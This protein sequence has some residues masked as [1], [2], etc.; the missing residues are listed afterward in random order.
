[1]TN[2]S[3]FCCTGPLPV[4]HLTSVWMPETEHTPSAIR[5]FETAHQSGRCNNCP[6]LCHLTQSVSG[7]TRRCDTSRAFYSHVKWSAYTGESHIDRENVAAADPHSGSRRRSLR[8]ADD[9][10]LSE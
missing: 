3:T 6:Q 7:R 9:R 4:D 10:R 2:T 8:S 5:P 1:M